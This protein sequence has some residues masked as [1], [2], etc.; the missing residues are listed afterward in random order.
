LGE[1]V[2]KQEMI[3]LDGLVR[4]ARQVGLLPDGN[5]P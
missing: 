4:V 3:R 2:L 1:S 5:Q